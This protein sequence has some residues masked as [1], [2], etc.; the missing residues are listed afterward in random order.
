LI[1][2]ESLKRKGSGDEEGEEAPE[3]PEKKAKTE[4]EPAVVE[5]GGEEVEATA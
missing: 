4:D 2:D 3:V 5:E 1:A